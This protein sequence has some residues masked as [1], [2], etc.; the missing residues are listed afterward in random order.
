LSDVMAK[1]DSFRMPTGMAGLVRYGEESK[2]QIKVKP[3]HVIVFC[4]VIVILELVLK[5]M[6]V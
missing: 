6:F 4:I 2:E 1:K 5:F 3:K